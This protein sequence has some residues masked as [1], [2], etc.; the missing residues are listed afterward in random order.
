MTAITIP[1]R[2][3][4]GSRDRLTLALAHSIVSAVSL[5]VIFFVVSPVLMRILSSLPPISSSIL[6][7][8]LLTVSFF[9]FVA[10]TALLS[11][12]GDGPRGLISSFCYLVM[13]S[14]VLLLPLMTLLEFGGV[15]LQPDFVTLFSLLLL[16]SFHIH[17]FHLFRKELVCVASV[18]HSGTLREIEQATRRVTYIYSRTLRRGIALAASLS[19]IGYFAYDLFPSYTVFPIFLLMFLQILITFNICIHYSIHLGFRVNKLLVLTAI[20]I[21]ALMVLLNTF[22]ANFPSSLTVILASTI[23]LVATTRLTL[24]TKQTLNGLAYYFFCS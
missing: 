3:I 22:Y 8:P 6:T 2:K 21:Q 14:L 24:L 11:C 23:Y 4:F 9:C 15:W 13:G 19:G 7:C 20:S 12:Q 10:A 1:L 18:L 17:L 16:S 5:I